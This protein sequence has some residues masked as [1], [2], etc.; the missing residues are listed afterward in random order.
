MTW[1][2][3]RDQLLDTWPCDDARVCSDRHW[4]CGYPSDKDTQ[5]WMRANMQPIF[6][7]P[8]L[9]RF[10]WGPALEV[11]DKEP[12]KHGACPVSWPDDEAEAAVESQRQS[13]AAFL[14]AG[15]S[16]LVNGKRPAPNA[17]AFGGKAPKAATAAAARGMGAL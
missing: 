17:K 13:M 7:W 6:G 8:D 16:P 15:G 3:P 2:V 10:S 1:Q 12:E 14:G 11:L 5:R 4:G 9:V